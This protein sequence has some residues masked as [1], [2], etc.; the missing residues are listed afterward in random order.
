MRAYCRYLLILVTFVATLAPDFASAQIFGRN[1]CCTP[2]TPS[3]CAAPPAAPSAE[4]KTPAEQAATPAPE[5]PMQIAGVQGGLGVAYSSPNMFG[6][7]FGANPFRLTFQLPPTQITTPTQPPPI[8]SGQP[9]PRQLMVTTIPGRIATIDSPLAGGIVERSKISEDNNPLPRDRVFFNYDYFNH[10][11]LSGDV[12]VHN[13]VLGFEKT[14][15]DQLASIEVRV[16]F[17]STLNPNIVEGNTSSR[18]AEFGDV[19]LTLKGLLWSTPVLNVAA[20]IG[21]S[22]PTGA[23]IKLSLQDGTPLGRVRNDSVIVTPYIAYLLTPGDRWFFQNWFQIGFDA[24]SDPVQLNPALATT[25]S[26]GRIKDQTILQIDAQ[27]GYWLY[28]A[29]DNNRWINALAP[30][31]E[32]HYNTSL[33]NAESIQAD[34][35]SLQSVNNR[36]DELN[37][38]TGVVAQIG[39]NCTLALGAVFPLKGEGNRSFD[40]Q[41]GLRA[42]IFF[43]PTARNRS[44]ATMVP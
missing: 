35:L 28:K 9:G 1:R 37:L 15:F 11:P 6:D 34:S 26:P 10:V 41:L 8:S 43:G 7:F 2:C 38:S 33:D 18:D 25:S 21:V 13:F 27:L 32:L 23:D 4:P 20:G 42:N 5:L 3:D 22:I 29:S 16:P 19:F 31:I 40:Y 17:A 12:N 24:N 39:D 44:R 36:F 14:F 30:F